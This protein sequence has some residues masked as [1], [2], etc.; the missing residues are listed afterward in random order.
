M[1]KKIVNAIAITLLLCILLPVTA[2][3]APKASKYISSYDGG[4][5]WNGSTVEV[6]FDISTKRVVDQLGVSSIYLYESTDL[7]TWTLVKS[8][9]PSSYPNMMAYNT[10]SM[11][12]YVS[13]TNAVSGRHYKATINYIVIS[14]S[15]TEYRTLYT[16]YI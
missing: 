1:S 14:G 2:Y 3:A 7:S 9:Y 10:F 13:Y 15:D 16:P 8:F 4:C 11:G 12:S 5:R 6:R